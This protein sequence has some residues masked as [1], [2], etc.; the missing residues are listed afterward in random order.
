[1]SQRNYILEEFFIKIL[2]RIFKMQPQIINWK[3]ILNFLY[4]IFLEIE[5]FVLEFEN[6]VFEF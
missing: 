4:C 1:M 2:I 6:F 3:N 5:N